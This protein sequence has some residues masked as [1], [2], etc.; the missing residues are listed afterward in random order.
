METQVLV[1]AIQAAPDGAVLNSLWSQL[2]KTQRRSPVVIAAY[3][4]RAA[5][6]G[7]DL[8]ALDEVEAALRRDWSAPLVEVYGSLPGADLEGRLRRAEG[9]QDAHPND[10]SLLLALGSLCVRVGQWNKAR[11]YLERSLSLL[12]SASAWEVLGDSYVGQGNALLAQRCYRN[13]LAMSRG[14]LAEALPG[15]PVVG[16]HVDTR[17]MALEERD[18]HGVP[19]L[20]P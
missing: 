20:R 5:S 12:P 1:A 9:W 18:E 14:E 19:R 7:L 13:A 17:A 10:A 2:P 6:F 11:Q 3:A 4:R 15:A 16:G 8:P